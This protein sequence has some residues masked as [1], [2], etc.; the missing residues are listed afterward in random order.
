[1]TRFLAATYRILD[2]TDRNEYI[3]LTGL[4][5]KDYDQIISAGTVN[6]YEGSVAQT[7]LWDMFPVGTITGDKFRDVS[8]GLIIPPPAPLP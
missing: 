6:F 7:L 2:L 8:N 5:K 3:A 1:M 4:A